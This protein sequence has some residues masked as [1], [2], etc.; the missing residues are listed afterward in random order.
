MNIGINVSYLEFKRRGVA[1]FILNLLKNW[2]TMYSGNNYYLYFRNFI[3]DD[4]FL[5]NGCLI[6]KII[7]CPKLID[8][9]PIWENFFL[10]N[11]VSR[12]NQLDIFFSPS[13]TMPF[14]LS[15]RKKIVTIFDIS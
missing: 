13:Y 11:A 4:K 15:C 9:Y 6:K 1:R 12:E 3:P 5:G 7:E 2:S 14:F 8:I 10:A